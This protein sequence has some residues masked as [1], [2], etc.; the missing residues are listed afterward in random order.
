[1]GRNGKIAVRPP[2]LPSPKSGSVRRNRIH[3]VSPTTLDRLVGLLAGFV[4]LACAGFVM[5]ILRPALAPRFGWMQPPMPRRATFHPPA[6]EVTPGMPWRGAF[7]RVRVADETSRPAAIVARRQ[8]AAALLLRVDEARSQAAP[9]P[10]LRAALVRDALRLLAGEVEA[11]DPVVVDRLRWLAH[12]LAEQVPTG[13]GLREVVLGFSGGRARLAGVLDA[14][15]RLERA[16]GQGRGLGHARALD[17]LGVALEGLEQAPYYRERRVEVRFSEVEAYRFGPWFY[18]ESAP[19]P[20][21][22]AA[23]AGLAM[24]AAAARRCPSDFPAGASPVGGAAGGSWM[25]R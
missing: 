3:A 25:G 8:A 21:L 13:P 6:L 12:R 22:T 23:R 19:R 9:G 16:L 15:V 11:P 18:R 5:C 10:A 7:A 4:L 24:R 2:G 17:A 20:D 1:M 14:L